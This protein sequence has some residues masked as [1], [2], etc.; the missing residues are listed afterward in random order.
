MIRKKIPDPQHCPVYVIF[1]RFFK[2]GDLRR[3]LNKAE[4]CRGLPESEILPLLNDVASALGY[5][6]NRL[7]S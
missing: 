5:L 4:N 1:V 6:H 3:L 7:V 2:A